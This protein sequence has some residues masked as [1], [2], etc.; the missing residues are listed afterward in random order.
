LPVGP[1]PVLSPAIGDRPAWFLVR[2]TWEVETPW[3]LERL[4]AAHDRQRAA[5][6]HHRLI[7][8]A[9]TGREHELLARAGVATAAIHENCFCDERVFD[10]APAAERTFDAIYTARPKPYKR[11]ELAAA[12]DSLAL[13][14]GQ[15]LPEERERYLEIRRMLP[16]A[17]YANEVEAA[18]IA[19]AGLDPRRRRVAERLIAH[20][21]NVGMPAASVAA[22][23][24]RARVGLC[25]SAE[26]G[27]MQASIEYLLC[28]LPV[29]STRSLGGRE[30]YFDP[31]FARIVPDDAR[32]V[33]AAVR[34]L[35]D[36]RL[37]P[38]AIRAAAL[39]AI[40]RDRAD[41]VALV[42]GIIEEAT[43]SAA[44]AWRFPETGHVDAFPS[45]KIAALAL[46]V[47]A[48]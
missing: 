23:L 3:R 47:A 26:E 34:V 28:G 30:R 48:P 46:E 19:T 4:V 44:A 33:G 36:A 29:V 8:L 25:L 39:T 27:G 32:A 10:V 31:A 38:H 20:H 41:F 11:H 22:W 13:I 2:L 40:G 14:Y 7:V 5:H 21:R 12:V 35:A 42:R 17:V 45:R 24:N 37:D 16:R 9:N 6:P 43:G 15:V 18:R 1:A